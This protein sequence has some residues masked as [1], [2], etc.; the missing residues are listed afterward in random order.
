MFNVKWTFVN[1]HNGELMGGGDSDIEWDEAINFPAG[2]SLEIGNGLSIR[3][4]YDGDRG[5]LMLNYFATQYGISLM[6]VWL[7][8]M[9]VSLSVGF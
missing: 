5:H 7:K 2:I 9:G 4:M 6:Y 1:K 3:P 8:T